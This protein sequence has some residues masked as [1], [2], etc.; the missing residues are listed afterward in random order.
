MAVEPIKWHE[1][2]D[3]E[4]SIEAMRDKLRRLGCTVSLYAYPPGTRFPPHTHHVDKIDGVF[5]GRFKMTMHGE[6]VTLE[7][8]DLLAVPKGVSHSAEVVG[9]EPV[10]SLDG[11]RT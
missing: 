11:I 9:D 7:A 5:S 4:L 8:G 2:E 1:T 10:I 6:T 3:G